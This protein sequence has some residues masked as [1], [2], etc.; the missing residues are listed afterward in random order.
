VR[1]GTACLLLL[2]VTLA[3]AGCGGSNGDSKDGGTTSTAR[4]HTVDAAVQ[5]KLMASGKQVFAKHCATCH[6][7]AGKTAHPTFIESPIPNLDDVK[8]RPEYVEQRVRA[9]GFDMP[10]FEHEVSPAQIRAV[11]AY[12]SGIA[13][14]N[15]ADTSSREGEAVSL[16]QQLFGQH[17]ASCHSIA[18]NPATGRPNYPGTNFNFVTPSQEMVMQRV[19]RGIKEEM[20]SFRGKLSDG[21]IHAVAVYVTATAGR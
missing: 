9:G 6:T 11:V 19:T 5:A 16:G 14:R 12:V 13:G 8:P 1:R 4:T 15:V 10:G 7:I 18:G 3:A 21:E 20:P 17:C 2:I